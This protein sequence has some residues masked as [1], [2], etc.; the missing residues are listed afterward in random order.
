MLHFADTENPFG[1]DAFT[2]PT[3]DEIKVKP[4]KLPKTKKGAKVYRS[5]IM[6]STIVKNF[7]L[8]YNG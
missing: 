8:T 5:P 7:L 4:H 3:P 1:T 2:R 6:P